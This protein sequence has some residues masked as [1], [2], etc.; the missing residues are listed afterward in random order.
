MMLRVF[1]TLLLVMLFILPLTVNV[2]L[3][4]VSKTLI[5]QIHAAVPL[6]SPVMFI[7][8]IGQFDERALFLVHG[9][10]Q[11]IWLAEDSIWMVAFEQKSQRAEE[12]R[13][14]ELRKTNAPSHL[15]TSATLPAHGIAI[16]ISFL[17]ANPHPHIEPFGRIETSVN[18]FIGNDPAKWYTNVPVW[19]GVRYVDLYPG[20]DLELI[21]R[22]GNIMQRL[23]ARP[24][25]DLSAVRMRI[26]GAN[27]VE[28]LSSGDLLLTTTVGKFI[29]PLLIVE[30]EAVE[31]PDMHRVYR[32]TFDITA[33][34]IASYHDSSTFLFLASSAQTSNLSLL[35]ASFLGGDNWDEG[36]GIAV[37]RNGNIYVAGITNSD[38]FPTTPGTYDSVLNDQDA[39]V[40]KINPSGS[41]LLYAT[42]IGGSYQ[43][44]VKDIALDGTGNI[45][46]TGDT[47]S[48][49]FPTTAGAYD[50]TY[51]DQVFACDVFVVKL[52]PGGSA[53]GYSTFLGGAYGDYGSSIAV[54]EY[55]NAYVTGQ[56]QSPDFPV[57]PGAY[58]TTYNFGSD[59]FVVKINSSGSALNYATFIGGSN[60][61]FGE[62]IAVDDNGNAYL[63]GWTSSS[64]FPTTLGA[65]DTTCGNSDAFVIKLNTLG[66]NLF[67][68]TCLGGSNNDAGWD[69]DV[70]AEGNVYVTGF[71][72]S[73]DFPITLQAYDKLFGGGECGGGLY[74]D[75]CDDA[76]VAKFNSS[77]NSLLY[78]TF[79]GGNNEDRATEIVVDRNG[80]AYLTGYTSSANF[81]TTPAAYDTTL[82]GLED[83]FVVQLNAAGDNLGYATFLGGNDGEISYGIV[84]DEA[85]NV[86]ITGYTS[87]YDFPTTQGAYDSSFGGGACGPFGEPCSDAFVIKM[88]VKILSVY[89]PLMLRDYISYFEGPWEQEPNNS[90]QEAN[91][92]LR[93]GRDYYGYP[94]D[95]KDYFSIYLRTSGQISINLTNHTD[96][97]AQLQLFYQTPGNRVAG[98]IGSSC[99]VDYTGPAGLYYIYIY[100]AGNYNST[101]PYTLRV[102]YPQ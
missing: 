36:Q 50:T 12:Q 49:D 74:D 64:N 73:S 56:T 97:E 54:D 78:S 59:A 21:G 14:I 29:I 67:Y 72:D 65:Y 57:T 45:Y 95:A 17:G 16:K 86:Y 55:G 43:D 6:G 2:D 79:L 1:S 25:A 84:L 15:R 68:A 83:V 70:D 60:G 48:Y 77:G 96:P 28:V 69:I 13:S 37:D 102:T 91:G 46:I 82:N 87:S 61:E 85:R 58:D 23:K 53:L 22:G 62:G 63:T 76:F 30:G 26:E 66:S 3:V 80:N 35:Y 51:N 99:H 7:Q 32:Q 19:A 18:Y 100:T 75:P 71:T 27:E 93:S 101:T 33:P 94:N 24:G 39:F 9:A 38:D 8:N 41:A 11:T 89:L 81:P 4:M 44:Y 42:F 47:N 88:R 5:P 40:V 92:P 98:C 52:A 20:I 31:E 34:F 10:D 90:A